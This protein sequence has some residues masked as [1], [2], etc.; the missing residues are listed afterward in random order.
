[1]KDSFLDFILFRFILYY[2]IFC[3]ISFHRKC[4]L[5]KQHL[6]WT[7]LV[8]KNL[9]PLAFS[10]KWAMRA[11]LEVPGGEQSYLH[12]LEQRKMLPYQGRSFSFDK[13]TALGGHTWSEE[14]GREH[15]PRQ[16]AEKNQSWPP[17]MLIPRIEPEVAKGV[18]GLQGDHGLVEK[19]DFG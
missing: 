13:C 9:D 14:G 7:F 17:V 15:W 8:F 2:F 6:S 18:R 11:C 19:D 10:Y 3:F 12:T 4:R 16:P 5:H 1:M